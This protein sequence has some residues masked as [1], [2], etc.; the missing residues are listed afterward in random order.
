MGIPYKMYGCFQSILPSTVY[1]LT[2]VATTHVFSLMVIY[3]IVQAR[4]LHGITIITYP[5]RPQIIHRFW[6]DSDL[7]MAVREIMHF[8]KAHTSS[9]SNFRGHFQQLEGGTYTYICE[10]A[11]S[12]GV[13]V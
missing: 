3:I 12:C 4:I 8:A 7:H 2:G 10:C 11:S 9:R 1:G 6:A 13:N 5:T